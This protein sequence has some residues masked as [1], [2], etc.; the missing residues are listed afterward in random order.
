[1]PVK[2]N[3]TTLP[4][5][6]SLKCSPILRCCFQAQPPFPQLGQDQPGWRQWHHGVKCRVWQ[7]VWAAACPPSSAAVQPCPADPRWQWGLWHSCRDAIHLLPSSQHSATCARSTLGCKRCS[8]F[9]NFFKLGISACASWACMRACIRERA[10]NCICKH[11]ATAKSILLAARLN[12]A[13][14]LA[15]PPFVSWPCFCQVRRY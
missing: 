14:A 1:M 9:I 13:A 4:V 3:D 12:T 6:F 11:N 2:K 5:S 10:H 7:P 15:A 8:T